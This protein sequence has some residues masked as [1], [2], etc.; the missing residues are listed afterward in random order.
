[1]N[2]RPIIRIRHARRYWT[3]HRRRLFDDVGRTRNI[4]FRGLFEHQEAPCKMLAG[5]R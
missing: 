3:I 5:R 1:M 4:R 2:I